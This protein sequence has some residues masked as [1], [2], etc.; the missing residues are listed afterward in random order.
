MEP[1]QIHKLISKKLENLGLINVKKTF[2]FDADS[3]FPQDLFGNLKKNSKDIFVSEESTGIKRSLQFLCLIEADLRYIE[4]WVAWKNKVFL[5]MDEMKQN[6]AEEHIVKISF[7]LFFICIPK[8]SSRQLEIMKDSDKKNSV[9]SIRSIFISPF[10]RKVFASRLSPYYNLINSSLAQV[11]L[12]SESATTKSV[13]TKNNSFGFLVDT[14][15]IVLEPLR[16]YWR[17]YTM[18]SKPRILANL[19]RIDEISLSN[20]SG[21]ITYMLGAVFLTTIATTFLDVDSIW[22]DIHI[23]DEIMGVISLLLAGVINTPFFH[24]PLRWIG[25]KGEFKHSLVAAIYVTVTFFP[26]VIIFEGIYSLFFDA[27]NLSTS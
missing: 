26:I 19:I 8:P 12:K 10:E 4:K 18:L 3:I 23:I 9:L 14:I 21:L 11:D 27:S 1:N 16:V 20:S 5:K 24:Y 25:G 2:D 17:G 6:P 13:T 22:F 7:I 15:L